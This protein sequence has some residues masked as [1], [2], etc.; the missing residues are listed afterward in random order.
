MTGTEAYQKIQKELNTLLEQKAKTQN[1]WQ[2]IVGSRYNHSYLSKYESITNQ[3]SYAARDLLDSCEDFL[4][5]A[6]SI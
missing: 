1:G 5:R 6:N 2:D 4:N 3:Y